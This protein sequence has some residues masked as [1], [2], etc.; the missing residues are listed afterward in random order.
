[1]MKSVYFPPETEWLETL[2]EECFVLSAGTTEP[3]I[4][5]EEEDW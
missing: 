3:M 1:M 4:P 5:E 2:P